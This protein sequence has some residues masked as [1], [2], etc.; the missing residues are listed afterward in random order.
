MSV[1]KSWAGGAVLIL[2]VAGGLRAEVTVSQSND[3]ADSTQQSLVSVLFQ[4]RAGFESVPAARMTAITTPPRVKAKAGAT[5]AEITS[6]W[7]AAQPVATGGEQFQCLATA[8]YQEARGESLQ[9]QVAVAEVVLNRVD[10]P[11]FPDT[12]C[13]VVHQGNSRGCQF[14]WAC[15]GRSDAVRNKAAYSEVS[16]IA[17][18]MMDGAPRNLTDGATYFHT[19]AVKP[20]WSRR[21]IQTARI[22]AHLFYAN[23]LKTASN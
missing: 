3:P 4:E 7:L 9:G 23:P 16:K 12:V 11:R 17:R 19:R 2:A 15:D 8:I 20:S 6:E 13:G 1:L 21:F 5:P 14:S 22:G 10:D 18:V